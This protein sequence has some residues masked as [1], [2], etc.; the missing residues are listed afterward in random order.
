MRRE[1]DNSAREEQAAHTRRRIVD[2][3]RQVVVRNGYVATTMV[4]IAKEA[5]VSRET[6]YKAVRSKPELIKEMTDT[7]WL[8]DRTAN[9][10]AVEEAVWRRIE[11]SAIDRAAAHRFARMPSDRAARQLPPASRTPSRRPAV[12]RC[13][14]R[15]SCR[16]RAAPK[17]RAAAA[18]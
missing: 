7:L 17:R 13:D 10:F 9:R 11:G 14:R 15:S 4:A 1:Y 12:A 2:A 18:R 6:V 3:A 5:R 8:A 16:S